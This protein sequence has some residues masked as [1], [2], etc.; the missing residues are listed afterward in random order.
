[1]SEDIKILCMDYQKRSQQYTEEKNTFL[2]RE[3]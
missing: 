2:R 1:M 3:I